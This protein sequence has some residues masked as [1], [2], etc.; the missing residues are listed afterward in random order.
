MLALGFTVIDNDEE[1]EPFPIASQL[2]DEEHWKIVYEAEE[3]SKFPSYGIKVTDVIFVAE[4][5]GLSMNKPSWAV[6]LI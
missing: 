2:F 4:D 3:D 1:E 6:P 5:E